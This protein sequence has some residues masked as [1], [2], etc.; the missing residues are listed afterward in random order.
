V[1]NPGGI[2]YH[3][4]SKY[5]KSTIL[6]KDKDCIQGIGGSAIECKLGIINVAESQA[7]KSVT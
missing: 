2:V 4:P 7:S 3:M 1:V 5:A 6:A